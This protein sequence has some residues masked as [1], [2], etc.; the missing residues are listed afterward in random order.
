[1]SPVG[2]SSSS[3]PFEKPRTIPGKVSLSLF[4]LYRFLVERRISRGGKGRLFDLSSS[5]L[6]VSPILRPPLSP[7]P[8]LDAVVRA[9]Y[10]RKLRFCGG[11]RD[12]DGGAAST[13]GRGW[14][15]AM[16]TCT[17]AAHCPEPP[18]TRNATTA[19]LPDQRPLLLAFSFFFFCAAP[20]LHRS[21]PFLFPLFTEEDGNVIG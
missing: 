16:R 5:P 9:L 21:V 19:L 18:P 6:L 7:S 4:L 15:I 10:H 11:T 14:W 2:Q 12:G 20:Y 17:C 8:T 13:V 1:M 3:S